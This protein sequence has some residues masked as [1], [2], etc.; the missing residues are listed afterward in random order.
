MILDDVNLVTGER[1]SDIYVKGFLG[2]DSRAQKTDVYYRSLYGEGNFNWRFVFDFDYLP[3]EKRIVSSIGNIGNRFP[4]FAG[5]SITT[6]I[7][8]SDTKS[9]RIIF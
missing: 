4:G 7:L 3:Q 1:K 5:S 9:Q 2:F 6:G 8:L